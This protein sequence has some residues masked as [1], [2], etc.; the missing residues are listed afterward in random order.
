MKEH[1]KEITN[2]LETNYLYTYSMVQHIFEKL[3]VTQLVKE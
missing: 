2:D 3:I 1:L